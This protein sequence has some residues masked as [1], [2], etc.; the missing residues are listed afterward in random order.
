MFDLK[1]VRKNQGM[2]GATLGAKAKIS[3]SALSMIETGRRRPSV[4]LTKRLDT[5]LG[6]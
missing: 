4:D 2:T 3:T 1:A 6:H 5:A